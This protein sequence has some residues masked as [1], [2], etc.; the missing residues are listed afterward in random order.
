LYGDES[1]LEVD[2]EINEYTRVTVK[3]LIKEGYIN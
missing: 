2:S 1:G 3:I